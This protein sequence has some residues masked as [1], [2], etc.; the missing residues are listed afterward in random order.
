MSSV[1][2]APTNENKLNHHHGH[3]RFPSIPS[4]SNTNTELLYQDHERLSPIPRPK[5]THLDLHPPRYLTVSHDSTAKHQLARSA[6]TQPQYN[7][8]LLHHH[9]HHSQA[10]YPSSGT[11]DQKVRPS[12]ITKIPLPPTSAQTLRP[13]SKSTTS[14][15]IRPRTQSLTEASTKPSLSSTTTNHHHQRTW[16]IPINA[17]HQSSRTP[18]P[19]PTSN[20]AA[21]SHRHSIG[22]IKKN[23]VLT[24]D[25]FDCTLEDKLTLVAKLHAEVEAELTQLNQ[26]SAPISAYTH[27]TD[28]KQAHIH[29]SRKEI[30]DTIRLIKHADRIKAHAIQQLKHDISHSGSTSSHST[31]TTALIAAHHPTQHSHKLTAL[32]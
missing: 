7:N 13:P 18:S 23:L 28:R 25:G 22:S 31:S 27:H 20:S 30:D 17:I 24:I 11:L 2:F 5:S 14:S 12:S 21:S 6:A 19:S 8:N 9:H 4:S 26:L 1:R 29:S 10:R 16:H 32:F 15:S 3:H